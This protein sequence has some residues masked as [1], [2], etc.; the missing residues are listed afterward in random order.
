MP[1]NLGAAPEM[2]H[3]PDRPRIADIGSPSPHSLIDELEDA[4]ARQDLRHRAAVMRQ[5]T[6]LFI[7]SGAGLSADH[8]AMFDDVMSR[9]VAAIDSS[10]RAEFGNLI[11]KNPNAPAKTLRLLA[12]DDEIKVAGPVLSQS[13]ALDEAT[14][15]EGAR[16][17]SQGHL[18]AISRRESISENI[19]DV[20]VERGDNEVLLNTASN[21]G[22][23]FSEGGASALTVRSQNN[24]ELA[25]RVWLRSDIPRQHLLALFTAA[26]EEV[27]RQ[28]E[29]CDRQKAQVYRYMVDLAKNQ[30][31]TQIREGSSKYAAARPYIE[32]LHR[33]GELSL[34]RLFLFA[35]EGKF[36]E[37]TIAL[38]L[39]C[40]LPVG[41]I[42]RAIVHNQVDY[43]LVLARSIG[44][45]W[46][47]TKAILKMR[48]PAQSASSLDLEA[49]R[50]TFA[51]LQLKTAISLIQFYRLRA[52]AEAQG[53]AR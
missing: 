40:E 30:I 20:L 15:I 25:L 38:S 18:L 51:K 2:D 47:A 22:A 16:T 3:R 44:L 5:V 8:I 48:A 28:F 36:D 52:R 19:T 29:A 12:L 33:S 17:K 34:E 42:E 37:V 1:H 41:H 35:Q 45:S 11:A 32:A 7:S 4:I 9:L 26:S 39:M 6:D 23:K 10:A 13:P 21:P 27:Q 50:A 46:D 24:A 14:L 53:E 31:Q 43:L 49:H